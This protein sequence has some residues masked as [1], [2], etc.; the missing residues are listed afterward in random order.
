MIRVLH[1]A[2][3]HLDSPF[4]A[5]G[6]EKD[7]RRREEQQATLEEKVA[8]LRLINRAKWVLIEREGLTEPEAHRRIEKAAMDR[9]IS[10]EQ[11][12]REIIADVEAR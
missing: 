10:R 1:A 2:D 7:L 12:A 4:Q 8:Q 11:V 6:R 5:L 3:L 9:R